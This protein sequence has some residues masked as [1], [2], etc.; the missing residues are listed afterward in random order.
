MRARAG[1]HIIL[2]IHGIVTGAAGI[3][4][5]T[6][7]ATITHVAGIQL[8]EDSYLLSYLLAAAEFG[9]SYLSF[10]AR[11]LTD[12]EA[13]RTVVG[14]CIVFHAA[15]AALEI[16]ALSRGANGVL[17]LNVLA[18]A[19]IVGVFWY[20]RPSLDPELVQGPDRP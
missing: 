6:S 12:A 8:A 1:L 7:P 20:L 5:V 14:A 16:Y 15:S 2:T 9:F 4:L 17:W 13:L 10:A 3:V 11:R 18:R 19:V